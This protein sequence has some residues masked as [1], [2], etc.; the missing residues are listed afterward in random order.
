MKPG[1]ES[2]TWPDTGGP[3]GFVYE[4]G[5]VVFFPG[6]MI[7]V[8]MLWLPL[9]YR[10]DHMILQRLLPRLARGVRGFV[11]VLVCLD[12]VLR[13]SSHCFLWSTHLH[14]G[15][16]GLEL[17]TPPS[18]RGHARVEANCEKNGP[19][20]Y[21]CFVVVATRKSMLRKPCAPKVLCCEPRDSGK[22]GEG[23]S[24]SE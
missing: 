5:R 13:L 22:G 4:A 12:V 6:G 21:L 8:Y 14:L 1:S 20:H 7:R 23:R 9:K 3:P 15:R 10:M 17:R 24:S 18:K 2:D 11:G 16:R 19:S